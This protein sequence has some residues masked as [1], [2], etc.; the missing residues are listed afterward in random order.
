[1]SRIKSFKNL[2]E[3]INFDAIPDSTK[4]VVIVTDFEY[5]KKIRSFDYRAFVDE[6]KK[7]NKVLWFNDANE[8]NF[9]KHDLFN[10]LW[11]NI[12]KSYAYEYL[13]EN[14]FGYNDENEYQYQEYNNLLDKSLEKSKEQFEYF[15]NTIQFKDDYGL[16]IG[17]LE[18][19]NEDAKKLGREMLDRNMY[20]I[21]QDTDASEFDI[22]DEDEMENIIENGFDIS[23]IQELDNLPKRVFLCGDYNK[24]EEFEFLLDI[25]DIRYDRL[26][27]F[28]H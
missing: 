24:I 19:H 1:M 2:N 8:S 23:T 25:L 13:D 16:N 27:Q 6:L 21:G 9:N 18:L 7:F 14:E 4:K 28:T 3:S 10:F 20:Y 17:N 12:V 5:K 22:F 26:N 11:D 15:F